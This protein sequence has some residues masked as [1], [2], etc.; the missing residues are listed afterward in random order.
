MAEE[1][2]VIATETTGESEVR[3][4]VKAEQINEKLDKL[5]DKKL[6]ERELELENRKLKLDAQEERITKLI[7]EA[8]RGGKG[9]VSTEQKE[10][11]PEE[12]A[13]KLE[14]GEVNPLR[15]DGFV[16]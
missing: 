12:Y 16:K 14:K 11:T 13:E 9:T 10:D 3:K 2:K 1:N 7:D 15:E 4:E 5:E 8:E 6:R